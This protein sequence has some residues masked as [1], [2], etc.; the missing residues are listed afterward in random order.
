[1]TAQ[2]CALLMG[3][4]ADGFNRRSPARRL[5]DT[6]ELRLLNGRKSEFRQS[7]NAEICA[8]KYLCA[9]SLEYKGL[10]PTKTR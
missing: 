1:M 6:M 2:K 9:L 10:S 8:A 7:R 3:K 4:M 5:M